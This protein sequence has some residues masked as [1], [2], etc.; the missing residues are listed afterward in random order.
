[1]RPIKV[2]RY[3]DHGKW[4]WKTFKYHKDF[5]KFVKDLPKSFEVQFGHVEFQKRSYPDKKQEE[6]SYN[7]PEVG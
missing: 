7:G 3:R 6:R 1:M 2:V 4:I 5:I